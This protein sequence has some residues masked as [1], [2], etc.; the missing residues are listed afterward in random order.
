M[1]DAR[2]SR[3]LDAL[4]IAAW[5]GG[6]QTALAAL[7]Q[8]RG[9]VLLAHA[10]RLTDGAAAA[11]EIAQAAWVAVWRGLAGLRDDAA[12]L[13]FALRIVTR[14]AAQEV[15]RRQAA[16][17]LAAAVAP[18]Q[19]AAAADAVP[20]PGAAH[21]LQAALAALPPADRALV[22]LALVEEM[23]GAELAQAL[24]IP[25]GTVKSRLFHARRRLRDTLTEGE[26]R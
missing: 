2:T 15:A 16:R 17:R 13:A 14:L 24:D 11:E 21:D 7:M 20:D 3:A 4:Q 26:T 23:S 8:R 18:L 5:R 22:T 1:T 9:P 10:R 25:V 12:F 19:E 6:D